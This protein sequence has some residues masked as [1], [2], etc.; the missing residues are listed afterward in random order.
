[1]IMT[2]GAE[3]REKRHE[4][5]IGNLEGAVARAEL[6][7]GLD[8][9]AVVVGAA[10]DEQVMACGQAQQGDALYDVRRRALAGVLAA[11]RGPSTW[12]AGFQP[13][14]VSFQTLSLAFNWPFL[15]SATSS[16]KLMGPFC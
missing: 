7:I 1:M 14:M 13:C 2:G 5:G 16:S 3:G 10:G 15:A 4:R 12:P 8:C 11:V 9:P 6:D